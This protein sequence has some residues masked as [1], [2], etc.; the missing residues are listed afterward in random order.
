MSTTLMPTFLRYPGS[1]RRLLAFLTEH[2]P[3]AGH[4]G[5]RL[6]E[7]FVG[8]GAVYFAIAPQR[9]LLSDINSELIDLYRGIKHNPDYVWRLYRRIPGT[10]R[11]YSVER[12]KQPSDLTL[13]R[14]AARSLYLNRTC[15]KGMW[16]HNLRGEFN[17]G[18]GGQKRRWAIRRRDL[19]AIGRMLL[20]AEIECSDFAM[21]VA[22][23]GP[24]DFIFLDPPYRPGKREQTN[25]HYA[26]QQFSFLDQTRLATALM[27]ADKRG[28]PWS[29]TNSGHPKI[30]ELYGRFQ[31]LTIPRGT[32][33]TIGVIRERPGEILI[34]NWR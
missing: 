5:G 22:E 9:A 10:K 15:F 19:V 24:G 29:M 20:T 3:Q 34:S 30:R 12:R 6:V 21:T 26:P 25:A 23:A 8:G 1:K 32:S 2:L 11:A 17:I 33:G 28:I 27:A 4:I 14:R 7:P 31:I 18:Y 16:R 13:F